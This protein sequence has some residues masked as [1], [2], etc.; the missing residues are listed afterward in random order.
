MIS[1]ENKN[2]ENGE[3]HL[4]M[5]T[6]T[7]NIITGS[8]NNIELLTSTLIKASENDSKVRGLGE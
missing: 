6:T 1:G 2:P 8:V 5:F 4:L 7:K 3:F